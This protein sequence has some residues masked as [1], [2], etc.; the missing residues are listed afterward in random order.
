MKYRLIVIVFFVSSLIFAGTTGKIAGRVTDSSTNEPI[1][2][3]NVI[4]EGT[5]FGTATDG[6]GNYV[7]INLQPGKYTI[8][9]SAV[10]FRK[11]N[12]QDV[13][14]VADFTTRLDVKL[15]VE[16]IETET[17][18]VQAQAPLVRKDLTSSHTSLDA[19]QIETLPVESVNQILTLQAGITQGAGG[20]LHIRGG[21]S[22]EIGYAI[23]DV[24]ITNPYD[25][26]RSVSIATNAIQELSV[27][28]GTFNAEYG[29][30]LSGIVNTVTKE[31]AD[32][33]SFSL[34]H[35]TGDYL[36]S[37]SNIF[38]NIEKFDLQNNA[39]T[40]FTA[41]GP[42][43]F[44]GDKISFFV[45]GRYNYDKGYLYGQ[46]QHLI[47]DSVSKN[48]MNPNDFNIAANGDNKLVSMN[49]GSSFSGTAKLT[50]RP[51]SM[52]KV[53]YDMVYSQS[54]YKPYVHDLKYNP[55][56]VNNR[57][58]WSILHIIEIRHALNNNSFYTLRGSFNVDDFKRYLFP[59]L[60]ENNNKVDFYAGMSLNGLHPDLRYEPDYKSTVSAAPVSFSS[61]GTYEGGDQSH[62]YQ[63]SKI[64]ALKFDY[65]NQINQS[66]ELKLGAQ[67][68]NYTINAISF[69]ILRDS[70]QYLIPT[71]APA[72]SNRNNQYEKFPIEFSSYVQ[73]KMEFDKLILNIGVRFDYFK[74][75]SKYSTNIFYPTP[76]QPGIPSY[77]DK[78]S[79]L[80]EAEPKYQISPRIGVSFP[81]T[82]KGIIHFSYG[83]FFQ[84][85]SLSYL[86]SNS[87][88]EYSFG[89]PTYGNPNLNPEKT[90]SYEL[91]LQQQLLDNLAFNLTGYY[92]DVRDLLAAQQIRISGEATYF[93]YVNKD[94][95]NIRGLIFSLTKRRTN[96]DMLGVTLDYTFQVSEGNDVNSDAFFLDLSS[97]RQSEK[98]PVLLNWDKTHQLNGTVSIGESS[99]WN[100]TLVGKIGTGLPYT[101]ELFGKQVS[102]KPNTDRRPVISNVDLLAEKSFSIAG[103]DLTVFVK[104]FNLFDQ[105][106][107]NIV[108]ANTGRAGYT[109]DETRGPALQTDAIAKTNPLVK[110][111]KE[112][113][114]RPD[115]Y[116]PPREVRIGLSIEY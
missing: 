59:L 66:H 96:S 102:L 34:S 109:L 89:T 11:V 36:S 75:N 18:I 9:F 5:S 42:V 52:M 35:Y 37:H 80:K 45:S 29:N 57:L 91:G 48:P 78:N 17:A 38:K 13:K 15:T 73:D 16:S 92:K 100:L 23:N 27:I 7:L 44:S 76:Y 63:R 33:Y 49:H 39:V 62:F 98:I 99:N 115:F 94:Y 20:E 65:T 4:V 32:K 31:G 56:A 8:K 61:G 111:A 90:V 50:Y 22:S 95:A 41:S 10:G 67:L 6:D 82:D 60:D 19:S 69:D 53:N 85:P 112:V 71:I 64:W 103:F 88:Y 84:L 74:S 47:S 77:I 87:E 101:P 93:T 79:L 46:R 97:G 86:Y 70:T 106:N 54:E 24:A 21:R 58:S 2:G 26:S 3:V 110:T 12:Y 105:L 72:N 81:I 28:S 55:D 14:V 30:A 107:E 43:P 51:F 25:N 116:L 114:T 83:H 40:E 1:P 108:Y 104:V 113:Y 68:R